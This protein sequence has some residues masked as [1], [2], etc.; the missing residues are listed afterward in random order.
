[1]LSGSAFTSAYATFEQFAVAKRVNSL[2]R[3]NN[4]TYKGETPAMNSTMGSIEAHMQYVTTRQLENA[5]HAEQLRLAK[6]NRPGA[7]STIVSNM[8][9]SIGMVLI[10]IGERL[11]AEQARQAQRE[12]ERLHST[13]TRT[14]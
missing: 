6:A 13:R 8:R 7:M 9:T 5:L 4:G 14:T 1:M 11:Q 10:A 3:I 2:D 12:A